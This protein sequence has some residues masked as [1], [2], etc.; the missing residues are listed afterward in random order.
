MNAND[1]RLIYP[2]PAESPVC[3]TEIDG[4]DFLE[5]ARMVDVHLKAGFVTIAINCFTTCILAIQYM[6]PP[7]AEAFA[8]R[9]YE[10][11][12][13][14]Y[15]EG[16]FTRNAI[17]D[18]QMCTR[19]EPYNPRGWQRLYDLYSIGGNNANESRMAE[20]MLH[21]CSTVQMTRIYREERAR[22]LDYFREER[23][24]V[25]LN[26]DST[27]TRLIA[28]FNFTI[29]HPMRDP[30]VFVTV[31]PEEEIPNENTRIVHD[32]SVAPTP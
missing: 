16:N 9:Y 3:Q 4:D 28:Q 7:P 19:I 5:R 14:A 24:I 11:R 13:I 27:I 12:S 31:V 20:I 2:T 18:A 30:N 26:M 25:S 21:A 10:K 23:R 1:L 32:V 22:T 6:D 15:Q 29:P 17:V 8:F